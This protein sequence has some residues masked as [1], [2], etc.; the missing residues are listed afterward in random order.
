MTTLPTINEMEASYMNYLVKTYKGVT[1][2]VT[3]CK[4]RLQSLPGEGMS[5]EFDTLLNGL[6]KSDPGLKTIKGRILREIEKELDKYDIWALW[7][8][9]IPGI[10]PAIASELIVLSYYKFI[11]ICPE[12]GG[13]LNKDE[14]T[15]ICEKCLKKAKKQGLLKFKTEERDFQTI[16]KF[17]AFFGRHTVDGVMPKRAKG[18]QANWSTPGR[19]LGFQ[20]AEMFNRQPEDHLYQAFVLERKARHARRNEDWTKGH[21]H[22]AARNEMIKLFMSHFWTVDRTIKGLPVSLPYAGAIMG[23]T[24]IIQPFYWDGPINYVKLAA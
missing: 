10:G 15:L 13:F 1:K 4:Q 5:E 9:K 16:S 22:N 18:V 7:L 3:A 21:I 14:G 24:N 6:G 20:I 12:C 23:H 8:K 19:T 11:P 2:L 17:W